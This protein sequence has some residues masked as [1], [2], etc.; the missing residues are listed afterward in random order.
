MA[1][2]LFYFF[3]V[4]MLLFG[5]CASLFRDQVKRVLSLIGCFFSAA[6][7]C[8]MLNAQFI[9][10]ILIVVYMGAIAMLFLFIVMM[11]GNN[12][13]VDNSLK[14]SKSVAILI[15]S[16]F[17]IMILFIMLSGR[18]DMEYVSLNESISM[19][20][21]N[22]YEGHA[23]EVLFTGFILLTGLIGAILTTIRYKNNRKKVQIVEGKTYVAKSDMKSGIEV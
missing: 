19:L 22:I 20:G 11:I 13:K 23:I 21:K 18:K 14:L 3:A 6:V 5:C 2:I 10:T 15:S 17:G 7:L 4:L 9:A 12:N 1:A 16:I 8:I